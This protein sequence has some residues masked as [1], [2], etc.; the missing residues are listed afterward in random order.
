MIGGLVSRAA[1]L[2][3]C[4][5]EMRMR[6][7]AATIILCAGMASGFAEESKTSTAGAGSG[8][9]P[10]TKS[11]GS[12]QHGL[13]ETAR[14]FPSTATGTGASTTSP[15][16]PP[17]WQ[18]GLSAPLKGVGQA[19]TSALTAGAAATPASDGKWRSGLSTPLKGLD[20]TS[21]EAA[22][23][24]WR[25]GLSKPL[26]QGLGQPATTS[27]PAAPAVSAQPP[28]AA[29]PAPT[30]APSAAA[31]SSGSKQPRA[32]RSGVPDPTPASP[33]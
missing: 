24:K 14:T 33:R 2:F 31:S 32:L 19:A 22:A 12:W 15:L 25:S 1:I 11:S 8:Q 29:S 4:T 16:A 27:P 9:E 30:P 21:P 18:I 5:R 7:V 13:S 3:T 17:T 20:Q 6:W 23:S 28:A 10:P 26:P